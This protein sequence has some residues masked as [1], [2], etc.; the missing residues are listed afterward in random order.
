MQLE[1]ALQAAQAELQQR[2]QQVA[3]PGV[4]EIMS[5]AG[6]SSHQGSMTYNMLRRSISEESHDPADRKVAFENACNQARQDLEQAEN[7]RPTPVPEAVQSSVSPEQTQNFGDKPKRCRS[8]W[9]LFG[10]SKT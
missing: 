7:Y 1:Q 4:A 3:G 2:L 6:G 9:N 8:I 5:Q 10:G